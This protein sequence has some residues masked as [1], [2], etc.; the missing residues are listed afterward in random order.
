MPT[1][2]AVPAGASAPMPATSAPSL[3]EHS[4]STSTSTSSACSPTCTV[5]VAPVLAATSSRWASTSLTTTSSAPKARAHC[6][7]RL[8]IGPAPLTSTREPGPTAPLR[9]AHTPTDSGSISA[10]CSSDSASGSAWAKASW[11]TTRLANAP[12]TGGVP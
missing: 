11:M 8:P 7:A 2:T 5:P 3:P 10:P 12:S 1:Q 9:Q 4:S 6:A